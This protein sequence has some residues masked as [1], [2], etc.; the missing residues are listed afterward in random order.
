MWEAIL[1][2]PSFPTYPIFQKASS[3]QKKDQM[4]KPIL[5]KQM[6]FQFLETVIQ[7]M[8]P[9]NLVKKKLPL[10]WEIR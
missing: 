1:H 9:T 4:K 10:G 2:S 8:A 6:G 7:P 3:A 5:M